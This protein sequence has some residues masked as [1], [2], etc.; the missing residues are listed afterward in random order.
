MQHQTAA[1]E[2]MASRIHQSNCKW[3]LR[4]GMLAALILLFPLAAQAGERFIDYAAEDAAYQTIRTLTNAD[5]DAGQI[6]FVGLFGEE[7]DLAPVFR[8]GVIGTPGQF[9]FYTRDEE[10]WD[11]LVDEIDFA[12]RR[13]DVMDG[14]SIQK[15]GR[16]QGV[17]SLLYGDIR[18]ARMVDDQ[19]VVRLALTLAEVETGQILWS[20]NVE[21]EYS[22]IPEPQPLPENV[23]RAAI[24]A[25][26]DAAGRLRDWGE[27]REDTVQVFFLPLDGESGRQITD[28]IVG[29][30]V[31]AGGE[32]LRFYSPPSESETRRML[33]RLAADLYGPGASDEAHRQ[34]IAEQ[35]GQI[36][37]G[38]PADEETVPVS[39]VLMGR[40]TGITESEELHGA[41]TRVTANL[42]M[43]NPLDHRNLWSANIEGAYMGDAA[44]DILT[45][46]RIHITDNF[47]M[48][49][50][51]AVGALIILFVFSKMLKAVTRP[52]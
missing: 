34:R 51:V 16:I 30:I 42:Q 24:N 17:D 4:V 35:L 6:A 2:K 21:G 19:A 38:M 43:I 10:E 22:I 23:R 46:L 44:E 41:A 36:A 28:L 5:V 39:A 37:A 1:T 3:K 47:G 18:E 40:V 25:A 52:R 33:D 15:F 8:A 20:G 27:E 48:V 14:E 49:V 32:R 29:E 50:A 7:Q 13:S 45:R 9:R 12:N 31:G 11:T 26:G